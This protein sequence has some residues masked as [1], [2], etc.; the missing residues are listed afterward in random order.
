MTPSETSPVAALKL[1]ALPWH[2]VQAWSDLRA[3]YRA[4]MAGAPS[5]SRLLFLAMLSGLIWF[6]GQTIIRAGSPPDPTMTA[7]QRSAEVAA[8]FVAALFFRTLMLYGVAA[9][10]QLAMR[11]AGGTGGWVESRGATFW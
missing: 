11:K 2:M 5:E 10:A 7:D 9:L 8:H 1:Y 6:L 3:S 4:L